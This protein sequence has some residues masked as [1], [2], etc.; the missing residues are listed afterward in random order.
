MLGWH[1]HVY[2]QTDGGTSPASMQSARGKRIAAWITGMSGLNWLEVLSK[3]G[4]AI[5]LGGDGYSLR[6]TGT[7]EDLIPRIAQQPPEALTGTVYLCEVLSALTERCSKMTV[8]ELV[9]SVECRMG[10]WLLI[11][12]W[13]QS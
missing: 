7:A 13:D 6:F 8:T 5:D 2:K 1:I 9:E 11:E 3:A 10:E 12:A 4:K